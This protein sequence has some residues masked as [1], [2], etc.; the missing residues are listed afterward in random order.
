MNKKLIFFTF[1]LLRHFYFAKTILNAFKKNTLKIILEGDLEERYEYKKNHHKNDT[2]LNHFNLRHNSELDFFS[3][4]VNLLDQ[5]EKILN[6]KKGAINDRKIIDLIV[7]MRPDFILTYGCSI[8]KPDLI[9]LF[10]KKI[11]NVHLGISPYYKGAATNFHC[12]VENEFQFMGYSFI[13]MDEG[14]DTGEIIHQCRADFYN[15]DNPH[16]VGNRLIKRMAHDFVKLITNYDLISK[17]K[18]IVKSFNFKVFKIKDADEIKVQKLYENFNNN[19][20]KYIRIKETLV[21]NFPIIQQK[22]I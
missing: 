10:N 11:I 4:S 15:F 19:L 22:F 5:K 16:T 20:K 7:S 3:D 13:Y 12:L 21:T 2:I 17:Q 6:I 1:F 8:I 9:E 18:V 14:I